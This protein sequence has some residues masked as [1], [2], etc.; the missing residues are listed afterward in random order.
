MTRR[1]GFA[2]LLNIFAAGMLFY[3]V[4]TLAAPNIVVII[5]DDMGWGDVSFNGSE[6]RTPEI[7][8]LATEG[9]RLNRFYVQSVCSPTRATLMTGRSPLSTGVSSPFNPWYERG[10]SPDEK[11][12]PEYLGDAGYQTYAVGKWHLGPNEAIYH[13]LERGFDT[14]YG[15]LHG[16]LN[17]E[18]HTVFGRLDWQRNRQTVVESGHVTNLITDEAIRRIE[19]R[20]VDRPMFLYVTFTAPHSPLQATDETIATYSH[21]EDETRR[22]YAAMVTEMDSA[23]SRIVAALEAERIM[24]DTLLMFFTDNGGVP[25]LGASNAPFRGGKAS[26]WE[27][28]IRVPAL[29][30]APGLIESGAVFD[31][32]MTVM[33]LLPTFLAAAEIPMDAP[34]PI[35]GQNMW[36]AL[37]EGER[38]VSQDVVLSN[39]SGGADVVMNAFFSGEW[40]LVQA[41]NDDRE[42]QNYLFEIRED[43]GE[44]NDLASEHPEVVERLIARLNAIP[45]VE[46]VN[47][48]Q[49]PP[50]MSAPGAPSSIAPDVRPAAG[51]PYT[52]S[53]PIDY[54][55][56]NYPE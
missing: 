51:L 44:Q 50:D 31:Q 25:S 2:W 12:L 4:P 55:L 24:D 30:H 37:A 21:I 33:D 42:L 9:M 26:P 11:L 48:G 29:I 45:Q 39:Y 17:H 49:R 7:D 35:E 5:S 15:S 13:P 18:S 19:A 46:P 16:Y 34:K 28:G 32:R 41:L 8:R 53:G 22:L 54:P 38:I 6:I 3:A 10:L 40:K 14:F 52:Q 56:R 1:Y 23:V 36:P 43:P 27:G 47:R 20:D